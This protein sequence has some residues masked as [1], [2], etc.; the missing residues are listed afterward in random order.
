MSWRGGEKGKW[1]HSARRKLCR[2]VYGFRVA[3]VTPASALNAVKMF[4][5]IDF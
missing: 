3:V 4:F 1:R 2:G 5:K